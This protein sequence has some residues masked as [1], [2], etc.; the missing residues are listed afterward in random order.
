M[1]LGLF[2]KLTM[3][4]CLAGSLSA[5][6]MANE[7][8]SCDQNLFQQ[9]AWGLSQSQ[10]KRFLSDATLP[11]NR[12]LSDGEVHD[13]ILTDINKMYRARKI[14]TSPYVSAESLASKIQWAAQCTGHDFSMLSAVIKVE[15]AYCSILH[16]KSGGDSGCGQFTSAAI[17]FFKNQLRLPGKKENG[18]ALMK[19]TIEEVMRNCAPGS[20]HIN[21][22]SLVELFSKSKD[23]IRADLRSG[24]NISR[25]VLATAIY[26]KFYYSISGFYYNASSKSPGALSRYNG[27]GVKNYGEKINGHAVKINGEVC[28]KDHDF[29]KAIEIGACELSADKA[30]CSLTTPTF[31]I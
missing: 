7:I 20:S 31:E 1:K 11:E 29:L 14:S 12:N 9:A 13:R 21:E 4:L 30:V 15:S 3:L 2:S 28:G 24:K 16:N 18:S 8:N 25:D 10:S 26:L 22:N 17:G 19:K 23:E 5:P 6:L 27:G